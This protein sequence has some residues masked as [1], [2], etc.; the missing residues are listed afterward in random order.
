MICT[1]ALVVYSLTSLFLCLYIGRIQASFPPISLC[2]RLLSF[3]HLPFLIGTLGLSATCGLDAWG[4]V[5]VG[6]WLAASCVDLCLTQRVG[7]RGTILTIGDSAGCIEEE[8]TRRQFVAPFESFGR[9]KKGQKVSF[10]VV[11]D[12][13]HGVHRVKGT[14]YRRYEARPV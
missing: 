12:K 14:T 2:A 9:L 11:W 1:L 4:A 7:R 10:E 3:L 5:L 6:L 13:Y 8:G